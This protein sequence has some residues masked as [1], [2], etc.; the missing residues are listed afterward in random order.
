[1]ADTATYQTIRYRAKDGIATITLDRPKAMNTINFAMMEELPAALRAAED[2][3]AVNVAVLGHNGPHFGAGYDLKEPWREKHKGEEGVMGTRNMLRAC[4]G[5]E[6]APWDCAK[7]VI[8]MVRGYCL[9]GSCELAMMCCVTSASETAQLGE[10]EIRFSTAPPVVVVMPW[11]VGLKKARELLYTGDFIDAEEALRIG[12]VNR[13]YPDADLES[14]TYR[15]ARRCAA[16]SQE[17]LKTTKASINRGAEIAGFRQAMDVGVDMGAML[18]ATHTK[19][20][21]TFKTITEKEGLGAAIR[22]RESQFED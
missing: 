5:F 17:G 2:D 12:M 13:V 20:Y 7:P 18:D 1:M 22:W 14:E 15:Y 16:I 21:Q 9:A 4:I 3:A 11:T 19:I 8:A 6:F 10:P